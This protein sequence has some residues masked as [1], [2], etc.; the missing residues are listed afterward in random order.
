MLFSDFFV[1]VKTLGIEELYA[2]YAGKMY[3]LAYSI[4]KNPSLS[5]DAVQDAFI[6]MIA[7]M[8]K[9]KNIDAEKL[10]C[11]LLTITKTTALDALRKQKYRNHVSYEEFQ[12]TLID[13]T[14]ATRE[15][16][17]LDMIY[18]LPQKYAIVLLLKYCGGYSNR[19][20]ANYLNIKETTVRSRIKRAKIILMNNLELSLFKN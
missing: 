7:N 6:K 13:C 4:L 19:E 3:G 2:R 12:E 15:N 5:E 18:Q 8:E 16:R 9:S 10:F 17:I 14:N 1:P 11:L 20:I